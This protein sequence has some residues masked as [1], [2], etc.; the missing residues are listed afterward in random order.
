ML[1]GSPEAVTAR[2]RA[3]RSLRGTVEAYAEHTPLALGLVVVRDECLGGRARVWLD[4]NGR[5]RYKIRCSMRVTAYYG[6]DPERIVSVLDTILAVGDRVGSGIPFTS[7]VDGPLADQYRSTGNH[8]PEVPLFSA[9]GQTLSWD[10]V[11]D[12]RPYLVI[13]EPEDC[14]AGAPPLARCTR[15]PDAGTVADVRNRHGMVFRLDLT[16]PDYYRVLKK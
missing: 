5:E 9:P 6:A 2:E 15:D 13:E 11:R 3:E 12:H 1:A 10:P 8:E 14:P 7:D 16:A 4:S